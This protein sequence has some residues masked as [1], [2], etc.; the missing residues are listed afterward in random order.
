M[1]TDLYHIF[2]EFDKVISSDAKIH[3]ANFK[4]NTINKDEIFD[5][6]YIRFCAKVAFFNYNNNQKISLMKRNLLN[7]LAYKIV[8]GIM[9][10]LFF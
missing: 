2:G 5:V 3:D 10:R 9:K 1:I 6:F 7:K 4:I 8:D